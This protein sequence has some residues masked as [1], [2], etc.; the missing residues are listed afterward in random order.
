MLDKPYPRF[1]N[2]G[3][4]VLILC[5]TSPIQRDSRA[6]IKKR[7]PCGGHNKLLLCYDYF[8]IRIRIGFDY[9][10]IFGGSSG[11]CEQQGQDDENTESR[12]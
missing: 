1:E 11:F 12:G 7:T 6:E 4:A 5:W 3:S 10:A 9:A 2:Q 8:H